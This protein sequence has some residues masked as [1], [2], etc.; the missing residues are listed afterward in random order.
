MI[1]EILRPWSEGH[2]PSG[3][4][5]GQSFLEA[6]FGVVLEGRSSLTGI[7][8]TAVWRYRQRRCSGIEATP[9]VLTAYMVSGWSQCDPPTSPKD[10]TTDAVVA[11]LGTGACLRPPMWRL[12][13]DGDVPCVI[14][15][16]TSQSNQK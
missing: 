4:C 13:G 9:A 6:D 3:A 14:D 15:R 7:R 11:G 10:V 5:Y 16:R 2:S 8:E 12:P 1:R